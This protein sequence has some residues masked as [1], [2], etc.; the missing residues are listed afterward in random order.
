[1]NEVALAARLD[2]WRARVEEQLAGRLTLPDPGTRRLG[3][4]MR[5]STLGGGKRLR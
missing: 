1:M 3:E 5:Y 2:A 4:A